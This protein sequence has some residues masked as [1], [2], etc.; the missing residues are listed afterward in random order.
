MDAAA[1]WK[2]IGEYNLNT[3]VYQ[4]ALL[5]LLVIGVLA[6]YFTRFKWIAKVVLGVLNLFIAV[7]FF[8]RYGTEPIQRYFALPLFAATAVLFFYDAIRNSQETISHP[9][10]ISIVLMVLYAAYPVVS[11]LFGG[12]FPQMV[13]H[14]MPC[15]VATISIAVYSCYKKR[16]LLLLILL[17]LWG[18][19][20]VKAIIFSAYEDVILLLAG[21]YGVW[22]IIR[23]TIFK[24][25]L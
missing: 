20:G 12:V 25:K 11:V 14:I 9:K 1:F 5:A 23:E 7:F 6:S 15:P 4:I 18:L 24:P 3:E 16:N 17:S 2:V 13:T 10:P 22:L 8:F 19:T 21:I